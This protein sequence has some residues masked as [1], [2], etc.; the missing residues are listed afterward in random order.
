MRGPGQGAASRSASRCCAM[1][2]ASSLVHRPTCLDLKGTIGRG[3]LLLLFVL[4]DWAY[5]VSRGLRMEADVIGWSA[6]LVHP[7]SFFRFF[8]LFTIPGRL[9][10]AKR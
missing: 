10:C 4:A 6:A 5:H 3:L 9:L 2:P 8:V 1:I 7:D